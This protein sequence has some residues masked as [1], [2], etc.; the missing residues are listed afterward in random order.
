MLIPRESPP[1]VP[2]LPT[3]WW[4]LATTFFFLL[5]VQVQVH[6]VPTRLSSKRKDESLHPWILIVTL[7]MIE[8]FSIYTLPQK[9]QKNTQWIVS[10]RRRLPMDQPDQVRQLRERSEQ[11]AHRGPMGKRPPAASIHVAFPFTP[12]TRST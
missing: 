11:L 5:E 6:E 10:G 2:I 3:V 7:K 8:Y 4:Q 1:F 9:L 12:S